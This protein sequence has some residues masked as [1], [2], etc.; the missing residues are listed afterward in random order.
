MA[1]ILKPVR[2]NLVHPGVVLTEMMDLILKDLIPKDSF[3][4]VLENAKARTLAGTIGRS[5]DLAEAYL[6]PMKD[7]FITGATITSDGGSPLT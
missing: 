6:Y 3:K 7:Q 4:V 5:E 1:Q 2:V